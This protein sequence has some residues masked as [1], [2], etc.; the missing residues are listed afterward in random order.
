MRVDFVDFVAAAGV[1]QKFELKHKILL[2]IIT[3]EHIITKRGRKAP[4]RISV[5]ILR[6][7][8]IGSTAQG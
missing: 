5:L 3:R 8:R 7:T 2:N 1:L 6:G 4:E